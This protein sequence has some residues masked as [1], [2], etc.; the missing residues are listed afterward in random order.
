MLVWAVW[1]SYSSSFSF[2]PS[3][4]FCSL[5]IFTAFCCPRLGL[6]WTGSGW[7]AFE[8]Q[9]LLSGSFWPA[10]GAA[11]ERQKN[12][13]MVS[14]SALRFSNLSLKLHFFFLRVLLFF[15]SLTLFFLPYLLT[16]FLSSPLVVAQALERHREISDIVCIER[17]R[18]RDEVV[19]LRD[20]LKVSNSEEQQQELRVE[21]T[22]DFI[23]LAF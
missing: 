10:G 7:P 2:F 22:S 11:V 8:E 13:G 15:P 17:D 3:A 14:F 23:S 9:Q 19:R 6:W 5:L 12:R 21:N 18:L 20:L 16:S 4:F 1:P